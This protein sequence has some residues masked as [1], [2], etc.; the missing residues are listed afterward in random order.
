[1]YLLNFN[2]LKKYENNSLFK[3]EN[4]SFLDFK[5]TPIVKKKND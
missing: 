5:Q 1:M 2:R 4:F 3:E